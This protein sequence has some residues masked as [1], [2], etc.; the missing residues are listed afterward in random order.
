MTVAQ[1]DTLTYIT[2]FTKNNNIYTNLNENFPNTGPG[3]PGSG[4]GMANASYIF[5]PASY[6]PQSDSNESY[7]SYTDGPNNGVTFDLTSD[8]SGHDFNNFTGSLG[9]VTIGVDDVTTVYLL[10]GA[11]N[12]GSFNVTFTGADGATEAFDN[13]L[14]PDFNGGAG[15]GGLAASDCPVGGDVCVQT[16]FIVD[17]VGAGG[18]GNSTTGDT[19]NY[20]LTEV[21]I[22]LDSTLSSEELSSATFQTNFGTTL[23]LGITTESPS[24]PVPEPASLSMFVA[25]LVGLGALRRRRKAV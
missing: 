1:A 8:S 11:Y 13:I 25:G 5:N 20:D 3:T 4:V 16:A 2:D 17:S 9:P 6:T 14:V 19:N 18:T 23:L 10:V 22:T 12:S 15:S 7:S 24:V 21:G